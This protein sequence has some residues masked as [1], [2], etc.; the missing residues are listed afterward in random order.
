MKKADVWKVRAAELRRMANQAR[1]VERERKMLALADAFDEA[2]N[3]TER[4][5]TA[6][7]ENEFGDDI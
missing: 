2:A 7:H 5:M 6:A 3:V 4:A 1:E